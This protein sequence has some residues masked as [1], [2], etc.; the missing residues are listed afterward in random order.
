MRKNQGM[1]VMSGHTNDIAGNPVF[2]AKGGTDD[3]SF[4]GGAGIPLAPYIGRTPNPN[5]LYGQ[6]DMMNAPVT[7][8]RIGTRWGDVQLSNGWDRTNYGRRLQYATA[9][10]LNVVMPNIPGQSRQ[11]GQQAG[12]FPVK[13]MAPA[14]WQYH[15]DQTAGMQP[16]Y[17]GGPGQ[18]MGTIFNPGS[19]G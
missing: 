2:T 9:G 19:G 13:G 15:F 14:Q 5:I 6:D 8:N 17:P 11:S 12:D 4:P 10:Y 1:R 16:N 18:A 3:M 7:F